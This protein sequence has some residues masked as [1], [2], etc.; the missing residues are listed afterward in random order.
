MN[1]WSY[2][3]DAWCRNLS[4]SFCGSRMVSGIVGLFAG[5]RGRRPLR[6]VNNF[7][8]TKI[9]SLGLRGYICSHFE[10]MV[11]L[12]FIPYCEV[13][14]AVF[15]QKSGR[16]AGRCPAL[17]VRG[18]ALRIKVQEVQIQ[19]QKSRLQI[20]NGFFLILRCREFPHRWGRATSC[21]GEGFPACL[22]FPE[23]LPFW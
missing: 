15:F 23:A 5:R 4:R 11:F 1:I 16:G 9:Y 3:S 17:R 8:W 20:A 18:G 6:C 22:P 13:F 12:D 19:E 10:K 2:F 21:G 14:C 7:A